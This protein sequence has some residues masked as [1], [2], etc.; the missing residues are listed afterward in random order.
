MHLGSIMGHPKCSLPALVLFS[1]GGDPLRSVEAMRGATLALAL[2]KSKDVSV[3]R[4]FRDGLR[5]SLHA[6]F[7]A[8]SA[9]LGRG[10]A[11][12]KPSKDSDSDK[13]DSSSSSSNSNGSSSD[14]TNSRISSSSGGHSSSS[15]AGVEGS[16]DE[17][18]ELGWGRSGVI[19]ATPLS[20]EVLAKAVRDGCG[21]SLSVR[22]SSIQ[23]PEAG[24]ELG[25]LI[26]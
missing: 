6:G 19:G 20:R 5:K 15:S 14:G 13:A 2:E 9:L 7:E 16:C 3:G 22:P 21:F 25:S 26:R 8:A 24:M 1:Q 17:D 18:D 4:G 23:H 11:T 12:Q 10:A